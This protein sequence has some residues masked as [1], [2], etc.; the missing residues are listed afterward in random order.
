MA[1]TNKVHVGF[2]VFT[3]VVMKNSIFW[4]VMPYCPL[5][6]NGRFGGTCSP[7]LQGGR[8]S[9]AKI[10]R[11]ISWKAEQD[12]GVKFLRILG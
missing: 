1:K 10:Q 9:Q 4:D 8:I 11:E 2:E 6:V 3:P 5:K 7:H 12:G